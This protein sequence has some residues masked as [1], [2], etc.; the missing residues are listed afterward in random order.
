M[1]KFPFYF[2]A[3][4]IGNLEDV[5]ARAVS[6]LSSLDVLWAEDTRKTLVLLRRHG[7]EVPLRSFHDHNK[8]R[9][10]PGLIEELHGG[11][12]AGLVS[13][14][15]MPGVS[16]PGYYLVRRLVE[17]G[18]GFTVIPGASAVSTALV[19]SGMPTDRFSFLGYLP[20]K[21]G[22]LETALG[23]AR[24]SAGTTLFFES[25]HRIAK[26]LEAASRVLEDR[27]MAVVREMTKLHE[28][29]LRG[30]A[31]EILESIGERKLKGEI[32]L[33][34]RGKGRRR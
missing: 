5:S 10:T 28:E 9:V 24:D 20:R 33:V 32:T 13:D 16:D 19:L 18:I 26:T 21:K 7:I 3:T 1:R 31:R 27:E 11:V 6:V 15:G 2:I 25:P 8:E 17:E 14:A 30:S 22:A 29:V 23:E 12:T 34:V 4:P